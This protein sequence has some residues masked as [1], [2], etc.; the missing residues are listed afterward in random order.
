VTEASPGA[1]DLA[2]VLFV[3]L[4]GL[5]M[6]ANSTSKTQ[7]FGIVPFNGDPK[8]RYVAIADLSR[9]GPTRLAAI[10]ALAIYRPSGRRLTSTD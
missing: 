10:P 6:M 3:P 9:K 2:D 4:H 8:H 1:L 7:D 5:D